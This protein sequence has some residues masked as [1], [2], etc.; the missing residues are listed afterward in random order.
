[1]LDA[2][3]LEESIAPVVHHDG[4]VDDDLALGLPQDGV[5]V[6]GNVNELGGLVEIPLNDLEEFET[7]AHEFL[8]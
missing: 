8:F 7:V 4:K 6:I 3:T 5:D 2:I 1:M